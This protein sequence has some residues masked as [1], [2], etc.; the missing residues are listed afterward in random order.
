MALKVTFPRIFSVKYSQ[1]DEVGNDEAE[2]GVVMLMSRRRS[3]RLISS[4]GPP[5]LELTI[6]GSVYE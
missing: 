3:K 6:T 5:A 4:Q 2:S 1:V